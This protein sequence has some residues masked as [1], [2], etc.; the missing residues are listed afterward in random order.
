MLLSKVLED[1][2]LE[3]RW[4]RYSPS[5]I[6]TI[7]SICKQINSFFEERE[8]ESLTTQDWKRYFSYLRHEYIPP[9]KNGDISALSE[10]TIHNRLKLIRGFYNWLVEIGTLK[11][12]QR[13]DQKLPRPRYQS[14]HFLPFSE[15]E[16][17][18]LLDALNYSTVEKKNGQKYQMK[19]KYPERNRAIILVFLDT[20]MRSGE[21]SRLRMEDVNLE[22]K[23]IYIRPYRDGR[24]S[25]ARTVF[26]GNKAKQALNEYFIKT[27]PCPNQSLFKL[28]AGGIRY[29]IRR[30]GENAQVPRAHPHRFRSTFATNY[31]RSPYGDVFTLQRLLGHS[32]L[33][34]VLVYLDI[35]RS[36]VANKHQH[37]SPVDNWDL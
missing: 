34:M 14:P 23:E 2:V 18:R 26:I 20:G 25:R 22:S 36:D 35:A 4:G 28:V 19:R 33:D 8:L 11:E 13:P 5:Y 1:F 6:S 37:A 21:L 30:I 27:P 29:L 32:T 12:N 9:R 31:L 17:K 7:E 16:V 15:V 10:A 24:K 3:A